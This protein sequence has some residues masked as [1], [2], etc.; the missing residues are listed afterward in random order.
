MLKIQHF[1][2][3]SSL[4]GDSARPFAGRFAAINRGVPIQ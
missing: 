4:S 1:A 3:F 2:G